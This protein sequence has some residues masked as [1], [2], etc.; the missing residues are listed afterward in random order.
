MHIQH[1]GHKDVGVTLQVYGNYGEEDLIDALSQIKFNDKHNTSLED[2]E[3]K[4]E[5]IREEIKRDK[6][7]KKNSEPDI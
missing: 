1:F 5:Q 7:P 2:L 4:L 3:N 6:N